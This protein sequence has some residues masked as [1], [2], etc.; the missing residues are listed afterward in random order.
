MFVLAVLAAAVVEAAPPPAAS[1]DAV[2][3]AIPLEAEIA[4]LAEGAGGRVGA[5]VAVLET[6]ERAG[7]RADERFPMQSVYKLPIAMAVLDRVDKG[8]L[9]LDAVV[10]IGPEE[11][12]PGLHSPLRDHHPQ[13]VRLTV[14]EL[15]HHA[16]VQSDGTASDVLL[17]LAGGPTDVT[18]YL[19]GLGVSEMMVA[20]S[21]RMMTT[22]HKVQYRNWATPRGALS[23]LRILH[24]SRRVPA[25]AR[26]ILLRDLAETGTGRRRLKGRL[27]EGTVVAHKTGTGRGVE[28]VVA[29]TNDIGLVTLPDGRHMAIAVFVA[30]SPADEEA[31][32][33]VIARIARAAWDRFTATRAGG[34]PATPP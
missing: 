4:T 25:A 11:L 30:D 33:G 17:G 13:G 31:R 3:L 19:R 6:G 27:P 2:A 21:E 14:R 1:P 20:T 15:V 29:A 28:G 22:H 16:I 18:A 32:E 12:V 34:E 7:H 23:L 26:E 5:A 24:Q 9:R 10:P 8:L